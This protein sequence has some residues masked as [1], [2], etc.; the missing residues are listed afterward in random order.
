MT[1]Q[2]EGT[3]TAP[4]PDVPF[5]SPGGAGVRPAV[6]FAT[7]DRLARAKELVRALAV[8]HTNS[9]LYPLAH[10]L[11]TDSIDDLVSAVGEIG[12]L[13]FDQV[14]VN[15]YKRTVFV[16][17]QVFPE[18]S[19]TYQK[20]VDDF[21]VR[22]I[23]AITFLDGFSRKDAK[24]L[25][26][27]LAETSIPDAEAARRLLESQGATGVTVAETTT[28][29][30]TEGE[31]QQ[32]ANKVKAREVYDTGLSAMRDVETRMK[33]GKAIETDLL[34]DFISSMMESLFSDPAAVLGLTAI[35]SHDD[36]TLN[37]AI[38]VCIL[39]L[40]LGASFDLD[41]DSLRSLGL[42]AL[43]YD[44]GKVHIPED[45][46]NKPGPLTSDEWA[47]VKD[48]TVEGAELLKR[49]QLID[50]MPMVV[51]HE[52]HFRLDMQGYPDIGPGDGQHLFSK[53]V[54]LCDAYDA[55][56]TRRPFRREIR[57]DKALAVLMQGRGKAYDPSVTKAFIA[58]LGIYPMGA[59]VRLDDDSL[60]V[61]FRV[62][63]DDLLH[64]RVKILA[65]P[66]G[67]WLPEPST[68]DLRVVDPQTGEHVRAIKECIPAS[69]AGIDDA[70]QYL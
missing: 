61:V 49:I 29:D 45:I 48:H 22:G 11:L 67:R 12:A 7:P 3:P 34:H 32:R 38:N 39:S 59:I 15:L 40:S 63:N 30:G 31:S 2:L 33:L 66:E 16:E 62:N 55:M 24:A 41:E 70:W 17:N 37:H 19:V 35:K 60:A 50:H 52:H 1:D 65:D 36:Y 8:A 5:E 6:P 53:I 64:P 23:S 42:S 21:L 20:L 9:Q 69:E 14:T 28:L 4:K 25:V 44:I 13:G 27:L 58:L 51:A 54:A 43:L 47:V 46:L 68:V 18:E 26:N 57:P 56:T 10:P